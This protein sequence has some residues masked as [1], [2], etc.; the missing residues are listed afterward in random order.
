MFLSLARIS[1]DRLRLY[2]PGADVATG[3]TVKGALNDMAKNIK[4]R[5]PNTTLPVWFDLEFPLSDEKQELTVFDD[6]DGFVVVVDNGPAYLLEDQEHATRFVHCSS[7]PGGAD[8]LPVV[9]R[10]TLIDLRGWVYS[11][12]V[13]SQAIPGATPI[14]TLNPKVVAL[15][16]N[17]WDIAEKRSAGRG[18]HGTDEEFA[19]L[20]S[21][22]YKRY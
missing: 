7:L 6:K 16:N 8:E 22:H 3:D 15:L 9:D 21:T 11:N 18:G 14:S 10:E 13:F 12:G 5:L 19:N 2:W 4:S 1:C 20:L 17:L